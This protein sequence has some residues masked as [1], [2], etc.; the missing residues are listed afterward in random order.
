VLL[1][2]LFRQQLFEQALAQAN[3]GVDAHTA[4]VAVG[5]Q[6]DVL[7]DF[8]A[9]DFAGDLCVILLA[10]RILRRGSR[11]H[12]NAGEHNHRAKDQRKTM[13]SHGSS[14]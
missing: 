9:L 11:E 14:S 4:H 1:G 2:A 8:L 6:R 5:F 7:E 10:R 3:L 13:P 12:A